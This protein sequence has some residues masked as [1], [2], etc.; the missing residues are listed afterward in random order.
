MLYV[1]ASKV[2]SKEETERSVNYSQDKKMFISIG[3]LTL[4]D[5]NVYK[6]YDFRYSVLIEVL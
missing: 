6:S 1:K 5:V 2:Y 4:M 3:L